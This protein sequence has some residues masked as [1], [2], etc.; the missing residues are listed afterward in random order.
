MPA[1]VLPDRNLAKSM[2]LQGLSASVISRQLGVKVTTIQ[3]WVN[4]YRWKRENLNDKPIPDAT[5]AAVRQ[6]IAARITS[7]AVEQAERIMG[8]VKDS[9]VK[10]LSDGK[11]ASSALA[12]SYATARKA[13]GLDDIHSVSSVMHYHII[14]QDLRVEKSASIDAVVLSDDSSQAHSSDQAGIAEHSVSLLSSASVGADAPTPSVAGDVATSTTSD[15][16]NASDSTLATAST[17]P[18][19]PGA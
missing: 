19:T 7:L 4:R 9:Q 5:Q 15:A 1:A 2:W 6:D 3:Q 11:T 10:T 13:L 18:P 8:V 16:D 17:L 14:G 12:A